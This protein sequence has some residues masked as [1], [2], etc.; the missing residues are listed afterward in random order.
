[1][2]FLDKETGPD[3][4]PVLSGRVPVRVTLHKDD[5]WWVVDER[6]EVMFYVDTVFMYEEEDGTSPFTYTWDTETL[7]EGSHILT[8]NILSYND[9]LG[10]VSRKVIVKKRGMEKENE[11]LH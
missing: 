1:V 2:E 7:T 10:V 5:K 3:G 4:I 8:V 11:I 6:F 9:H